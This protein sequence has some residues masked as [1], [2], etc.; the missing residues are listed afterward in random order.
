MNVSC[1]KWSK[2]KNMWGKKKKR[3]EM[4]G[5]MPKQ[6]KLSSGLELEVLVSH[7]N[8][9]GKLRPLSLV[10]DLLHRNTVLLTPVT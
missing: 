3:L 5:G 4:R 6:T 1:S 8:S 2:K 7:V 9:P 10:V